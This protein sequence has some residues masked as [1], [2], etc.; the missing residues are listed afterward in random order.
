MRI[1]ELARASGVGVETIRF[2]EQKRLIGR[3]QR[4]LGGGHRNYSVDAVGR[5]VFIRRA[6]RLGFSLAEIAELLELKSGDTTPCREVRRRAE[7]KR[8]EVQSRL[9]S[10]ERIRDALDALIEACPGEAA[11]AGCSIIEAIDSGHL[12]LDALAEV[13]GYE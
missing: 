13:D 11:A 7:R 3:P 10:L 6:Q 4:P 2:Y 9:A 1:G 8:A 5:I 12:H